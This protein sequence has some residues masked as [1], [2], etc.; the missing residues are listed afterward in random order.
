MAKID[1]IGMPVQD[2]HKTLEFYRAL[3]LDI[4]RGAEKEDHVEVITPNG[5]R[6]A[7]DSQEMVQ[8]FDPDRKVPNSS[9]ITLAFLCDNA[10]FVRRAARD[11]AR[12]VGRNY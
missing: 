10:A 12:E 4:P 1:M 8:G 3:G 9:R 6:I 2:M 11:E 5:Y 7:W